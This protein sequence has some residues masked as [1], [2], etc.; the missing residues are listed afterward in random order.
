MVLLRELQS[1]LGNCKVNEGNSKWIGKSKPDE[2][3][4]SATMA[5]F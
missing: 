2:L 1:D 5:G 3:G 4:C